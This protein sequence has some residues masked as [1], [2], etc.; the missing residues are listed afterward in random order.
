MKRIT[1]L[2]VASVGAMFIAGCALSPPSPPPAPPVPVAK[3]KDGDLPIP[4]NYKSW[5]SGMRNVQRPDVK[6]IREIFV[7]DIGAKTQPGGAFANGS[8][9]VME[10]HAAKLAAD[11]TPE[12]A[13]DGSLIKDKLVKVFVM[14]KGA[15]WGETAPAGLKNGDWVYSA[16]LADGKVAP[17]PIAACRGCHLPLGDAKDYF[18]RYD[19]YLARKKS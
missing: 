12:K 5:S 1:A 15:G 6:Q 8:V 7:N 3:L 19:E 4:A 18:H 13:A 2:A 14:G 16:Y 11:G 10:I 17:D 9:S